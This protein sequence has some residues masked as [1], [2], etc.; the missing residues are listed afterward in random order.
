MNKS[1]YTYYKERLVE[2]GG[3]SRCIYLKGI[4]KRNSYDLGRIFEGRDTKV[5]KFVDY[6]WGASARHPFTVIDKDER[7][8]ILENISIESR[9]AS[10]QASNRYASDTQGTS[11]VSREEQAKIIDAEITKLR[12]LSREV[13]EIESETGR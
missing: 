3:G 9:I 7:R 2:I 1:I 12:E 5:S 8:E 13:D 10:A 11:H 4:A 6:L